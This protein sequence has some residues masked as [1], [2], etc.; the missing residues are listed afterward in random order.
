MVTVSMAWLL[1]RSGEPCEWL[2]LRDEHDEKDWAAFARDLG[3]K[4]DRHVIR[5]VAVCWF[6]RQSKWHSL[7][8][9]KKRRSRKKRQK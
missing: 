2:R 7:W 6:L 5:A 9:I 1:E 4:I 3:I 8:T